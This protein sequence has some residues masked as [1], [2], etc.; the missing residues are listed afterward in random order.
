[1]IWKK[2]FNPPGD[3]AL[4]HVIAHEVG[5]DRQILLGISDKAREA[6]RGF[7]KVDQN[8]LTVRQELQADRLW[9]IWAYHLDRSRQQLESSDVEE[10]LVAASAIGVERIQMKSNGYVTPDAFTHSSYA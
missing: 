1:V 5:H 4:A 9:G 7:G 2:H 8:R 6:K 3:F 10:G